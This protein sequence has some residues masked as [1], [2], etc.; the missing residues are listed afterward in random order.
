MIT[1]ARYANE[2]HTQV[3]AHVDGE[4]RVVPCHPSNRHYQDMLA[5]GVEIAPF[6]G[7]PLDRLKET[8]KRTIDADAEAARSQ[9]VT[10]G[11]GMALVYQEKM[12]QATEID[13][14]GEAE[15]NVLSEDDR[16]AHFPI[17]AASVGI[18]A[19]TLWD[20]AQLVLQKFAETSA[21]LHL[22]ERQRL[23]AKKAV[24]AAATKAEVTAAYE[25]IRWPT[26]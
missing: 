20:C 13:R 9:H 16:N 18:E 3:F 23:T 17:V 1:K 4:M 24:N 7:P 8:V 6:E 14:M 22:I 5:Q 21:A 11:A 25:A 19:E 12:A 15:A 2:D 26:L 10:L